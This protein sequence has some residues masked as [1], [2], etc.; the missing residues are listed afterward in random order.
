[1]RSSDQTAGGFVLPVVH[2]PEIGSD[3]W[4]E[5]RIALGLPPDEIDRLEET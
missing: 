4:V 1:M 2:P 3:A 5:E